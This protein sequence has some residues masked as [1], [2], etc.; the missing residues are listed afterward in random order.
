MKRTFAFVMMGALLGTGAAFGQNSTTN[1]STSPSATPP[2]ASSP[3]TTSQMAAP[4]P[5][6]GVSSSKQV[7]HQLKTQG[8]THVKGL[9][10]DE[11]G[12]W[13]GTAK[14]DGNKVSLSV[15]A[16]GNVTEQ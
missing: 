7:R 12:V 9:K 14:K 4:A 16:Q 5:S 3:D 2:A 10:K 13:H 8:Y 15:D 6:K 1:P 11:Q